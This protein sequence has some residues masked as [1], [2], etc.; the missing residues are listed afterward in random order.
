MSHKHKM[1]V[2][3]LTPLWCEMIDLM[4]RRNF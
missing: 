4:L 2:V 1:P 3:V